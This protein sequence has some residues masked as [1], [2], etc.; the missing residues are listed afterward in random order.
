MQRGTQAT[1]AQTIRLPYLAIREHHLSAQSKEWAS[2]RRSGTSHNLVQ[3]RRKRPIPQ[4]LIIPVRVKFRQRYM[5]CAHGSRT[6]CNL[7][8]PLQPFTAQGGGWSTKW[9]AWPRNMDVIYWACQDLNKEL[10]M[11]YFCFGFFFFFDT[12]ERQ[13]GVLCSLNSRLPFCP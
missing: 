3:L 7:E 1:Q 10:N 11:G 12:S 9:A 6:R 2:S 8:C 5:P 4:S 13:Y